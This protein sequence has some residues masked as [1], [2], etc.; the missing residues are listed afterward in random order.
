MSH[1]L[2]INMKECEDLIS[3]GISGSGKG[4]DLPGKR[5]GGFSNKPPLSSLRQ[6]T[7][8]AAEKRVR[9]G[10]LLPSGPKRLG[11]DSSLMAALSPI[12]AAAMA[13]ERR[14]QDNIWCG[15]E[16]YDEA[17]EKDEEN[18]DQNPLE[19]VPS[20]GSSRRSEGS[21]APVFP[22]LSQKRK[23][24]S[25]ETLSS[26]SHS[27]PLEPMFV[28]LTNSTSMLESTSQHHEVSTKRIC[29]SDNSLH[30]PV[31]N[32]NSA[33]SIC[34]SST[35][36]SHGTEESTMWECGTCTLL[37]PVSA[38]LSCQNFHY[39]FFTCTAST[40]TCQLLNLH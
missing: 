28:D 34:L 12:Q 30:A 27:G 4:F 25:R 21:S 31:S 5:L 38:E 11:G 32:S 14:L 24:W 36:G 33:A 15:S 40:N 20:V 37:N 2:L 26:Q 8:A 6:T 9:L 19:M 22:V 17:E 10:S 1:A 29:Q 23:H 13:A 35:N 3:K 39:L 7:L 18:N 16:S